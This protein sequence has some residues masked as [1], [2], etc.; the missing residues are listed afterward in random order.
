MGVFL[1]KL[2]LVVPHPVQSVLV[3]GI[4]VLFNAPF[5]K[6]CWFEAHAS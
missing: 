1:S 3:S 4:G 5:A 2:G 6:C